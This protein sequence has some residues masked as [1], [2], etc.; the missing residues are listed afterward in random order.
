MRGW[1]DSAKPGFT[2]E[3]RLSTVERGV[4]DIYEFAD[5]SDAVL[6]RLYPSLQVEGQGVGGLQVHSLLKSPL[7][8]IEVFPDHPHE[9]ECFV[10][11][12]GAGIYEAD[13]LEFEEWP[14]AADGERISPEAVA[15]SMSHGSAMGVKE[16]LVPRSFIAI[17]AYD[18]HT[19]DVGRVVTDA[20]WHHFVN[21]NIDGTGAPGREGFMPGGVATSDGQK[22]FAYFQNLAEWL[23]PKKVRLCLKWRIISGLVKKFPFAEEI[24]PRFRPRRLEDLAVMGASMQR[25]L[26][27]AFGAEKAAEFADELVD[28]AMRPGL[29]VALTRSGASGA[30]L[31]T[32]DMVRHAVLGAMS[33]AVMRTEI[34][35][36][37]VMK[38]VDGTARKTI[39][40]TIK[41]IIERAHSDIELLRERLD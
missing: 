21:I 12:V 8:R 36:D 24:N 10:P 30:R 33:S 37:R 19:A 31:A 9:G 16:A 4:N 7:G 40:R 27:H 23:M 22:V 11:T 29:R 35:P 38:Q 17:C 6:Q 25:T 13:G 41:S 15:V 5:Q 3:T 14:A 20:T 2:D 32:P 1:Y 39:R 34:D 28:L 18:G 26:T